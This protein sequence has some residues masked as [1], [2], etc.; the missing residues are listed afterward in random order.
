M[1]ALMNRV[2]VCLFLAGLLSSA[3]CRSSYDRY[4]P[5]TD[6]A[7]QALETALNAWQNGQRVGKVEGFAVPIEVV[8]SRWQAGHQLKSFQILQEEESSGGPKVFS[9]RLVM[10]RPATQMTVR[11]YVVGKDPLLVYREDD[12]KAPAGM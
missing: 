5:P 8:D 3:G 12:Y 10:K 6:H 7:Q 2:S 1:K 11:Y 4:I 9:V